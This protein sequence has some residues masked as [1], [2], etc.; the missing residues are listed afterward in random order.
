MLTFPVVSCRLCRSAPN[1]AE[2][3]ANCLQWLLDAEVLTSDR[4]LQ[5]SCGYTLS[6]SGQKKYMLLIMWLWQQEIQRMQER[7][8]LI[9]PAFQ[10]CK[11]TY[12]GHR[13]PSHQT[14]C[15][16][17]CVSVCECVRVSACMLSH[18]LSYILQKVSG[19][20]LQLDFFFSSDIHLV[21]LPVIIT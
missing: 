17:V 5:K 7:Y 6:S 20:A 4:I 8:I 19:R 13:I 10:L 1:I 21:Q 9:R 18:P 3:I 16:Y 15:V 14:W 11:V 12:L 2:L